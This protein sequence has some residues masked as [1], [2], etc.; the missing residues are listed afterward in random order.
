ELIEP[1]VTTIDP[2]IEVRSTLDMV[3][4]RLA[5]QG[6]DHE[7]RVLADVRA[8]VPP[9]AATFWDMTILAYWAWSGWDPMSGMFASA[10]G[11]GG[12]GYALP[13][14]IGASCG[15]RA[16]GGALPTP[17]VSGDGGA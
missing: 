15:E 16:E 14:A 8:A 7:R 6:L 9:R 13:A 11:A 2:M 4:R 3:E 10:Q 1:R 5:G 12:L 17:A